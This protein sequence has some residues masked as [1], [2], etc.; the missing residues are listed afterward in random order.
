VAQPIPEWADAGTRAVLDR[1]NDL[2][3]A[4][5]VTQQQVDALTQ[6]ISDQNASLQASLDSINTSL[7]NIQ[8]DIDNI[9]A[10]HPEVDLSELQAEVNN[11]AT[12][13]AGIAGEAGEA[14]G[15]DA[16]TPPA[17]GV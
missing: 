16:Q 7:A 4:I 9:A 2:E 17:S 1:L 10:A 13:T 15:I 6:Q 14:A 11:L 12:L 8:Q 5:L 3:G